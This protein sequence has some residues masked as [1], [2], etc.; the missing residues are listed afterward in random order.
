MPVVLLNVAIFC[1]D[2]KNGLSGD[3]QSKATGGRAVPNFL[4][5]ILEDK[6]PP[7]IELGASV[8]LLR[9]PNF[10][11][12]TRFPQINTSTIDP[13]YEGKPSGWRDD[14]QRSVVYLA[15]TTL[16]HS[17]AWLKVSDDIEYPK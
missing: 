9:R 7:E 16:A 11:E 17:E 8:Q 6:F 10:P 2:F 13:R 12:V 3:F 14:F 1:F 5:G 15:T 4:D